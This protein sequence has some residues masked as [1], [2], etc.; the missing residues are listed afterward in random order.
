ME[1]LAWARRQS[2][3]DLDCPK[4]ALARQLE[5]EIDLGAGCRAVEMRL[6]SGRCGRQQVLD[7]EA[8]PAGAAV[9]VAGQ[10]IV[11]V[12]AEQGMNEAAVADVGLG[13]FHQPLADVGVER[14]QAPHEQKVDEKVDLA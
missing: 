13:R 1:A 12:D 4:A 10:R 6:C 8:F 11:V 7:D 14:R 9:R 2:A 3:L 5:Q